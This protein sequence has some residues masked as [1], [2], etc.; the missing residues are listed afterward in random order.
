MVGRAPLPV[1]RQGRRSRRRH[2]AALTRQIRR[3]TYRIPAEEV[4][5]AFMTTVVRRGD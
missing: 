5:D 2:I 1:G 4:A 3:G